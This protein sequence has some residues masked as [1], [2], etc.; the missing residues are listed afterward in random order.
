MPATISSASAAPRLS[1]SAKT[2]TR[3]RVTASRPAAGG[4]WARRRWQRGS[5]AF[6]LLMPDRRKPG[7]RRDRPCKRYHARSGPR[8]PKEASNESTLSAP[9]AAGEAAGAA[10]GEGD[11]PEA[12]STPLLMAATSAMAVSPV[13]PIDLD[14]T[15]PTPGL[16]APPGRGAP[17][18]MDLGSMRRW[19]GR[20]I[21]ASSRSACLLAPYRDR[22]LAGMRRGQAGGTLHWCAS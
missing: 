10:D 1:A 15:C 7:L 16:R 8:R 2:R 12:A 17:V 11:A 14:L 19:S 5:A 4:A 21:G 3:T 6:L 18:R 22:G 9:E 13:T 20:D